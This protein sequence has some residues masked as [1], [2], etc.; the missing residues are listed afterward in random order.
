[1]T[2]ERTTR[3]RFGG[4][5]AIFFLA[6]L[7]GI[8]L[9]VQDQAIPEDRDD[10]R[11]PATAMPDVVDDTP[12]SPLA[13]RDRLDFGAITLLPI[14]EAG[15]EPAAKSAP[16]APG[17]APAVIAVDPAKARYVQDLANNHQIL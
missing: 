12:L 7:G 15:A 11:K 8:A 10:L 14:L 17:E 13:W 16:T 1:M 9:Y 3:G 4:L 6:T 5:G 2:D